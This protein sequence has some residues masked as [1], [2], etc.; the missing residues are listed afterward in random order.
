MLLLWG[1][2][3]ARAVLPERER[4]PGRGRGVLREWPRGRLWGVRWAGDERGRARTVL[5]DRPGREGDLLRKV[6]TRRTFKPQDYLLRKVR[7]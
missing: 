7:L 2:G 1:G 4:G 3:R 5:R 6:R